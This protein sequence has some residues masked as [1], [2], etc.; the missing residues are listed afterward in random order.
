MSYTE[1]MP[2]SV[3]IFR[4]V[5]NHP[6]VARPVIPKNAPMKASKIKMSLNNCDLSRGS[7]YLRNILFLH[8]K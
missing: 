8:R 4:N 5:L 1:H 2:V 6:D 3:V 7:E